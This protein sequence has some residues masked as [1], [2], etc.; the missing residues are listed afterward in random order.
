ME[1]PWGA[2]HDAE[3]HGS[4]PSGTFGALGGAFA[5]SS[6]LEWAVSGTWED[7]APPWVRHSRLQTQQELC[8]KRFLRFTSLP[9]VHGVVVLWAL[10]LCAGGVRPILAVLPLIYFSGTAALCRT[11]RA[12][13]LDRLSALILIANALNALHLAV[14]CALGGEYLFMSP[15]ASLA[16]LSRVL[17]GLLT[18]EVHCHLA[19]STLVA[20]LACACNQ[21]GGDVNVTVVTALL[22]EL[23]AVVVLA[24]GPSGYEEGLMHL[25]QCRAQRQLA[26]AHALQQM[27]LEREKFSGEL[28][29]IATQGIAE[30]TAAVQ[31]ASEPVL[32]M[33]KS[34]CATGTKSKSEAERIGRIGESLKD[35]VAQIL[36]YKTQ[37]AWSRLQ[38]RAKAR[39]QQLREYEASQEAES[40]AAIASL[41]KLL[42]N[43]FAEMH[44]LELEAERSLEQ[45]IQGEVSR[46][47]ETADARMDL[48]RQ[49]AQAMERRVSDTV[50]VLLSL[51]RYFRSRGDPTGGTAVPPALAAPRTRSHASRAPRAHGG[52]EAPRAPRALGAGAGA[53]DCSGRGASASPTASGVLPAIQEGCGGDDAGAA[54]D[55]ADS[56]TS[57]SAS[58]ASGAEASASAR[59]ASAGGAGGIRSA[60]ASAASAASDASAAS[61]GASAGGEA[62]SESGGDAHS[63][64]SSTDASAPS[65]QPPAGGDRGGPAEAEA[66]ASCE[67]APGGGGACSASRAVLERHPLFATRLCY[68]TEDFFWSWASTKDFRGELDALRA[69]QRTAA[70]QRPGPAAPEAEGALDEDRDLDRDLIAEG[71]EEAEAAPAPHAAP[72]ALAAQAAQAAAS[73]GG[74]ASW[75]TEVFVDLSVLIRLPRSCGAG[76]APCDAAGVFAPVAQLASAED[77]PRTWAVPSPELVTV[78]VDE[79]TS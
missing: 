42:G 48:V 34:S 1:L 52:G 20:A 49:S 69:W 43:S 79:N 41:R 76:D 64:E 47:I 63:Q 13:S 31:R 68:Q 54:S 15:F 67:A 6:A 58:G 33:L 59:S 23:T 19:L 10:V 17:F 73:E 36:R 29:A 71:A 12:S 51:L 62:G 5:R 70:S 39:S 55:G 66:K 60:A 3:P 28:L 30:L 2:A 27:D 8:A 77:K 37:V 40:R 21:R 44:E 14:L 38:E 26:R 53:G 56:S 65:A 74:G 11:G 50:E 25:A 16:P 75:P 18:R 4:T 9:H 45:L 46:A 7:A 72:A 24:Q 32:R 35:E 61:A 22:L 78:W 57:A